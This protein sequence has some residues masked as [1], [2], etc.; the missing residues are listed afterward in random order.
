MNSHINIYI[1][2]EKTRAQVLMAL[3]SCNVSK[4]S[5]LLLF[6]AGEAQANWHV[7]FIQKGGGSRREESLW[8][9]VA[10]PRHTPAS[11]LLPMVW[12]PAGKQTKLQVPYSFPPAAIHQYKTKQRYSWIRDR[13][14]WW[15]FPPFCLIQFSCYSQGHP[16]HSK[17]CRVL[18]EGQLDYS[19]H[20]KRGREHL[21]MSASLLM[22][23]YLLLPY[24]QISWWYS[25][26]NCQLFL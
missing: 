13:C 24:Q 9:R 1:W 19:N 21:E 26:C 3:Y 6:P 7:V 22:P 8:N 23:R 15:A 18:I 14:K 20:L 4:S 12:P 25:S 11:T 17:Y 16:Q 5:R 10:T 2:L